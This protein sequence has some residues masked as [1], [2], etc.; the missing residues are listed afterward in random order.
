[1]NNP[2]DAIDAASQRI[3]WSAVSSSPAMTVDEESGLNVFLD[4]CLKPGPLWAMVDGEPRI[5]A[6]LSDPQADHD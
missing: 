6:Q 4:S 5:V 2:E 1:M 3:R